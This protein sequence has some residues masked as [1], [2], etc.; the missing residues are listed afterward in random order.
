MK[1]RPI[2]RTT[3]LFLAIVVVWALAPWGAI[4]GS[5]DTLD[6]DY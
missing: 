4:A 5:K 2:L 6:E 3:S 1:I